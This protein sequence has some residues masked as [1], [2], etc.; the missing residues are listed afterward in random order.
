MPVYRYKARSRKG[1][2]IEGEIEAENYRK[3][4]E[5]LRAKDLFIVEVREPGKGLRREISLRDLLASKPNLKDVALFTRQLATMLSAG[6]TLLQALA[7]QEAQT[8][9]PGFAKAIKSIRQAVEEGSAFHEALRKHGEVFPRLVV[10]LV[11]SGEAS[12]GME[13]I[14]DR[15]ATYLEKELAIRGKVRSAMTYPTLVFVFAILVSYFLLA[16]VVPQFASILADIGGELPLITRFLI[17][18]SD[19]LRGGFPFLMAVLVGSFFA[20]RYFFRRM[21]AFKARVDWIKLKGP[22]FGPLISKNILASLLRTLALLQR[23]GV[24]VLEA[25]E[26]AKESIDNVH[27]QRAMDTARRFVEEGRP[28]SDAL[29]KHSE[30]FPPMVVSM[31]AIGEESGAVDAMMEKVAQHYEREVDDTISSLSSII[32]PTLIIFLGGLVGFIVIA[33]FMP[34]IQIIQTISNQ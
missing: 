31:V 33:L 6:I 9:K 28:F 27:I 13:V 8:Q 3:A 25:L 23:S 17:F 32:E 11:R 14:L 2:L 26:L 21:P 24:P 34:I 19:L 7:I 30:L 15:I 20:Y 1:E 16:F 18:V 12:G 29:R 4:I 22:I 10:N 5:G